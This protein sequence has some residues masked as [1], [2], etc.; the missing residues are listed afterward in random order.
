MNPRNSALILGAGPSGMAC[1]MELYKAGRR[2]T[3]VEKDSQVGGLSKTYV[4]GKFRTDIGG[5]RFFSQNK[6]LYDFI[7][8]LLKEK[9]IKVKRSSRFYIGGKFYN[10]PVDLRTALPTMGPIKAAMALK[11][12]VYEKTFGRDNSGNN[13]EDYT[14]S[15]FGR[16]LAEFNILNYTEKIW[17]I[18]C[19]NLSSQWAK[20]RIKDLSVSSIL[21]KALFNSAGPKTLVEEFYYP[22]YGTGTIYG[23][24]HEK[25]GK[26]NEVLLGAMPAEIL[27]KN[28]KITMV[29]LNDGRRFRRPHYVVS[30]IPI[31][32]FCRLLKPSPPKHVMDALSGLRFRSQVYLFITINKPCVGMDQWIY[33]PDKEVP[34]ARIAEMKNFSKSMAPH[35]KTSLFIEFFCWEGDETWKK[36]KDELLEMSVH[37]LEKLGFLRNEEIMDAWRISGLNAYPVYDIGYEDKLKE[38]KEYLD[39]FANLLYIGRPGRFRYTNQDHSLEM[40]MLAARAIISGKKP[41]F[42]SVGG[43]NEYFESGNLNAAGKAT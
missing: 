21:K 25:A 14:V 16:T 8:D 35:G 1:A 42:D 12:Y 36:S 4:F 26:R 38:V 40:G 31:T 19:K 33:F 34:F 10:Y 24:I 13:F 22:E 28:G 41:D 5:H 7:E 6:Y 15:R 32:A 11:D 43:K 9:W 27:H 29:S 17:G 2:F 20:Q 18:P 39:G 30:S 23:K 37:W 3:I